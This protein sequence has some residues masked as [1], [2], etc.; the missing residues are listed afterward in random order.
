MSKL[1]NLYK[2]LKS[3][4]A[5]TLYL[6]KSGIFYIFLDDDAKIINELLDL[7]L[8][9][10]NEETVKCGFPSNSLSKYLKLLDCTNY[11]I[12]I[13]DTSSSTIL[14]AKDFSSHENYS[15]LLKAI[16]AVDEKNLSVRE[17]Y[18]FISNIKKIAQ[19]IVEGENE[20]ESSTK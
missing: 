19:E 3:E 14:K 5:N 17:A 7:R 10:L 4:D 2:S 12:K 18:E 15:K 1:V 20:N 16:E 11:T 9:N 6:F 13:V 8:T